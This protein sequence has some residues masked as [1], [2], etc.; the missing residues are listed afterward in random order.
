MNNKTLLLSN[1]SLALLWIFTGLI[2]I[3]IKPS[4]GFHILSNVGIEG[5][6][7]NLFVYAGGGLDILLGIWV[8][9]AWKLNTC[10]LV[11]MITI[12]IFTILLSFIAAEFWLH[13]FGPITKNLPI[14]ALLA[15]LFT[16]NTDK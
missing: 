6:L 5:P 8:L 10:Y 4:V 1:I 7:A 15:I 11:Q 9:S 13:P 12:I 3:F 2:S 14:L 16:A